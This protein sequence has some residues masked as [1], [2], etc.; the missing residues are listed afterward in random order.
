[1]HLLRKLFIEHLPCANLVCGGSVVMNRYRLPLYS[2]DMIQGS[3]RM[4][5]SLALY[6]YCVYSYTHV[7]PT[8]KFNL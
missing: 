2:G 1:M 6:V 8:R 5:E 3:Q 4:A 7:L